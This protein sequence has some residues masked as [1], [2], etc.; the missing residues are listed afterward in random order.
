MTPAAVLRQAVAELRSAPEGHDVAVPGGAIPAGIA[1]PL[2]QWL[3]TAVM[4]AERWPPDAQTNSPFRLGAL[5][6]AR[7][8]LG[9]QETP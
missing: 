9:T 7:A 3:E 8:I 5:A 6:V 4:Y 2:A 1:E